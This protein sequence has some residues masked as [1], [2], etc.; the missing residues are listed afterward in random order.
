[1]YSWA[2]LLDRESR[3]G[4][5]GYGSLVMGTFRVGIVGYLKQLRT[6]YVT[7]YLL[8]L[9]RGERH[10]Q[11][12]AMFHAVYGSDKQNASCLILNFVNQR[13]NMWQ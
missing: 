10:T 12:S 4:V 2:S 7:E 5:V 8:P 3:R 9:G 13:P 6:R 11:K 1:M